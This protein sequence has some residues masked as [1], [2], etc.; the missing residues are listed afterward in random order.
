MHQQDSYC[1]HECPCSIAEPRRVPLAVLMEQWHASLGII[2]KQPRLDAPSCHLQDAVLRTSEALAQAT[3]DSE[4]PKP[5][6]A[7]HPPATQTLRQQ[8]DTRRLSSGRGGRRPAPGSMGLGVSVGPTPE[9]MARAAQLWSGLQ[10]R[11]LAAAS[12]DWF[13]LQPCSPPWTNF[14]L[15]SVAC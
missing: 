4:L 9:A 1:S 5:C 10:V 15:P 7:M 6:P 3:A 8:P 11:R 13:Y 12:M 2:G 14:R